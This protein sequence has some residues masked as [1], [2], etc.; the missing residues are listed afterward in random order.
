MRYVHTLNV[1]HYAV[2][3]V[4]VLDGSCQTGTVNF[5]ANAF[6]LNNQYS[7]LLKAYKPVA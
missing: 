4:S 2:H 5:H 3:D 1:C 7:T 6:I